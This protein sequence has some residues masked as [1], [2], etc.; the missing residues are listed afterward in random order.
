MWIVEDM[1]EKVFF[2][3]SG[4][5]D[6]F[7]DEF[8]VDTTPVFLDTYKNGKSSNGRR[9]RKVRTANSGKQ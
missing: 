3:N 8:Q 2:G 4:N 1:K 7:I 9:L 5:D 6:I